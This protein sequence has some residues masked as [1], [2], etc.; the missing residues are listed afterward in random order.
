MFKIDLKSLIP[1]GNST[2]LFVIDTLSLAAYKQGTFQKIP[3]KFTVLNDNNKWLLTNDLDK[4][5]SGWQV[6]INGR[7]SV[8]IAGTDTV[9]FK[10]TLPVYDEENRQALVNV[11][12]FMMSNSLWVSDR[13]RG[14][15]EVLESSSQEEFK[16]TCDLCLQSGI[17]CIMAR[18]GGL[19][20]F[21]FPL[22][23]DGLVCIPSHQ[24]F[25]D[26]DY[27]ALRNVVA[28]LR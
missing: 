5:S 14:A 27:E 28:L 8:K 1:A 10:R 9:P 19:P 6:D 18:P 11:L 7:S 4:L 3:S 26:E 17:A 21:S 16:F 2:T 13:A 15:F 25:A 23:E 22:C 12:A 24:P 20:S